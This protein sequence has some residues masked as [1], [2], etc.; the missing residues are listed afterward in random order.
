MTDQRWLVIYISGSPLRV[1]V[2]FSEDKCDILNYVLDKLKL[3]LVRTSS[4]VYSFSQKDLKVL[5]LLKVLVPTKIAVPSKSKVIPIETLR[6][7]NCYETDT[8][9]L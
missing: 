9:F 1:P 5:E 8:F 4:N 2:S 7:E 6:L 3:S